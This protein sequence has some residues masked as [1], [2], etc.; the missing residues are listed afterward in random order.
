LGVVQDGVVGQDTKQPFPAA[1]LKTTNNAVVVEKST[2]KKPEVC[3]TTL[4]PKF[5]LIESTYRQVH[6]VSILAFQALHQLINILQDL[7]PAINIK[8]RNL[9]ML[10]Q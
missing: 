6:H 1:Y 7:E 8:F 5:S 10:S 3:D 2:I 9:L 4:H